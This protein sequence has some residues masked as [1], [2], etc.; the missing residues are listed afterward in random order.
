MSLHRVTLVALATLFT[1]GMTSAALADCCGWGSPAHVIYAPSY[2]SS[3]CGGCAPVAYAPPVQPA[4]IYVNGCGGCGAPAPIY[5]EPVAPAPAPVVSWGAGWGTGCGCGRSVAYAPVAAEPPVVP[6][7]MYVTDQG[8][9]YTGPGVMIAYRT[10]APPTTYPYISGGY[11]RGYYHG[12]RYAYREHGYGHPHAMPMQH[13]RSY[14][15]RPLGVR[16]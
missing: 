6:A 13:W 9:D 8:P 12:S 7:P 10:W 11:G 15:H 16:G 1:A 14:P 5:V 2:Y 4:P 3:G